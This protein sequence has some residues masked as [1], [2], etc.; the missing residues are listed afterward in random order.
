MQRAVEIFGL[1]SG[2]DE[3]AAS[4]LDEFEKGARKRVSFD[5]CR[6]GTFGIALAAGMP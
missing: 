5:A 3:H 2:I 1:G 4:R 6:R